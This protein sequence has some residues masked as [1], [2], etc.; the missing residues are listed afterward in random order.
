MMI[1]RLIDLTTSRATFNKIACGFSLVRGLKTNVGDLK[2]GDWIDHE[3][4]FL[5]IQ[6]VTSTHSGRGA[7]SFLV[8]I[9]IIYILF[10]ISAG[11]NKRGH[12]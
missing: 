1:R 3:G 9:H 2:K 7:R 12:L 4:K 8:S 10:I 11:N 5:V 6:S